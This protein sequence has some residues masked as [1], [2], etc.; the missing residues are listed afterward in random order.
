MMWGWILFLCGLPLLLAGVEMCR[1]ASAEA[2][3]ERMR[4]GDGYWERRAAY[5]QQETQSNDVDG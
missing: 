5:E 4:W 2:E 3:R 1:D